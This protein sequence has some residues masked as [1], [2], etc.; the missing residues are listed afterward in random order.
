[1]YGIKIFIVFLFLNS[2]SLCQFDPGA[3][4]IAMSYSNTASDKDV[5]ALFNNPS[6]LTN[7]SSSE[8]G[9]YYS[10]AP[11]GLKELSN[12]YA[13]FNEPTNFGSFAL[14]AMDY[15]FD[16]YRE[17]KIVFG[18]AKNIL[19]NLSAGVA[20]NYH[21]VS[22]KN[23]GKTSTF[24]LDAGFLMQLADEL[25]YGFLV[26]NINRA[27]FGKND[28]HIPTLLRTGISFN[29]VKEFLL[30]LSFEKETLL[31]PSF[32]FGINYDII[33]FLSLR[34]G[35]S[36]EPAK[37]SGGLGINYSFLSLDYAFFS[38]QDL[39]MTHQAGIIIHL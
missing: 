37:F 10:P 11:F 32:L 29:P 2:F 38:H 7:I 34:T 3:K 15:G 14:G 39:G 9:I 16:L 19:S 8:V 20:L 18:Y 35:F 12:A 13:A 27:D 1:M 17:Y 4:Q 25:S 6:C 36:S 23:Y 5:F 26:K 33:E 22:I 21:A 30:N 28:N 24:Y 31:Q